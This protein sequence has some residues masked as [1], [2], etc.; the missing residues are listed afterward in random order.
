MWIGDQYSI[1]YFQIDLKSR[2]A[3]YD[4][5]NQI[6]NDFKSKIASIIIPVNGNRNEIKYKTEK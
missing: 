6:E 3:A 1:N 5:L 4:I 2:S